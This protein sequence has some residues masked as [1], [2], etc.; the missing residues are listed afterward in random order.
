[1]REEVNGDSGIKTIFRIWY[2]N[3]CCWTIEFDQETNYQGM[4]KTTRNRE[5]LMGK[6]SFSQLDRPT[7]YTMVSDRRRWI[8]LFPVRR[9]VQA[10]KVRMLII[11]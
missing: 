10:D 5:K 11:K 7:L 4:P 3:H 8:K 1:M 6:S 9:R 2:K